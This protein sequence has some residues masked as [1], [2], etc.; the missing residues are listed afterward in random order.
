MKMCELRPAPKFQLL[1]YSRI[2]S[3]LRFVID[4]DGDMATLDGFLSGIYG[5]SGLVVSDID[6]FLSEVLTLDSVDRLSRMAPD[7]VAVVTE[8]VFAAFVR[9]ILGAITK[10]SAHKERLV[11]KLD[12]T[13]RLLWDNWTPQG[14]R[15]PLRVALSGGGPEQQRLLLSDWLLDD[16]L[17][18]LADSEM[19]AFFDE[20]KRAVENLFA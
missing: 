10:A 20:S 12:Q 3:A 19:A 5:G 14:D 11:G 1:S 16:L 18:Y 13:K 17:V 8:V 15:K 9:R 7:A 4:E 2:D 6:G